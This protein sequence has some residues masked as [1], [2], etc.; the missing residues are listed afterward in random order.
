MTESTKSLT[1]VDQKRCTSRH[2]WLIGILLIIAGSVG[3]LL[4]WAI[5]TAN[6]VD[7]RL[8]VHEAA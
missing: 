4:T 6:A 5:T 2:Q 3:S 8:Q 1:Y 7:T